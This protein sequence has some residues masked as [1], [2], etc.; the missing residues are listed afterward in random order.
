MLKQFLTC[1]CFALLILAVVPASAQQKRGPST[2]EERA[3][4]VQI[5]RDLESN[6]LGPQ[7]VSE[8]EW[9]T[10]WLI[11]VP[12]ITVDVCPRLLGA[13][14][15]DKKKHGTEIFSQMLY[16]EAA[17]IIEKPDKA[18]DVLAIYV[19]GV[20]GSLKVYGAIL[21]DHP[22]DHLKVL[23]E[24]LARRDKGELEDQVKDAM[25]YCKK[26]VY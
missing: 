7:A 4:A 14:I 13:E 21:K 5:A 24:I 25:Q 2:P 22:K 11:E 18:K 16:S 26:N 10:R 20:S 1:V 6:P 8:R 19:A 9:I 12:D 23:D 3:K 15:P 17:F